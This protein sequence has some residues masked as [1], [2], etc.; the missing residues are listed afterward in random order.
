MFKKI[1][2]ACFD[3]HF[4]HF[5]KKQ[6]AQGPYQLPKHNATLLRW[7]IKCYTKMLFYGSLK[8]ET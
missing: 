2:S 3:G 6:E 7:N 1:I 8:Y 5:I 4:K